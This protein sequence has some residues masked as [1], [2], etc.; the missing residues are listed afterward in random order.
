MWLPLLVVLDLAV[1]CLLS[2]RDRTSIAALR[3]CIVVWRC[4]EILIVAHYYMV[5]HWLKRHLT[6]VVAS[7]PR[8]NLS[9]V[10]DL[11]WAF[12][13]TMHRVK[14]RSQTCTHD[15]CN[16]QNLFRV[17]VAMAAVDT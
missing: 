6:K 8:E 4:Q 1:E 5:R 15:S 10:E 3:G 12:A 7:F 14:K 2:H 13:A 16:P 11:F 17:G 9:F